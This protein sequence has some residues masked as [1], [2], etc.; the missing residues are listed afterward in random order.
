MIERLAVLADAVPAVRH[1][2][3]RFDGSGYPS[4]LAGNDIPFI[5]AELQRLRRG[6]AFWEA[7]Q[8][9]GG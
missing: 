3:E 4:G 8:T 5:E 1:H 9:K 7:R 6:L 2:H